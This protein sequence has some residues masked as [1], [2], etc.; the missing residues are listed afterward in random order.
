MD[1]ERVI[2]ALSATAKL[3]QAVN[4]EVEMFDIL[5]QGLPYEILD[6]LETQGIVDGAELKTFLQARTLVR[7]KT[8]KK[9]LTA[10]ESDLVARLVRIHDF[11]VEVFGTHERARKWLRTQNRALKNYLPWYLLR[12]D[13]GAR[14]VE[15]ELGR[16]AHGIFSS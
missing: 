14:I 7:R 3:P 4:S 8:K 11:A 12:T 15:S 13:Y 5:N 10:E 2:R 16:I 6:A 1:K 9:H